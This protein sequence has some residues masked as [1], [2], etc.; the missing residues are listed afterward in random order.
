MRKSRNIVFFDWLIEVTM[1]NLKIGLAQVEWGL[2]K[3]INI[4]TIMLFLLPNWIN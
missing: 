2:F 3:E 1:A 4:Y